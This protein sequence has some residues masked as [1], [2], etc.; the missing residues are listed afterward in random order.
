[1]DKIRGRCVCKE[2][3]VAE[4]YAV[5][6]V[7]LNDGCYTTFH[8]LICANCGGVAGT[9]EANFNMFLEK[10]PDDLVQSMC[11]YFN[12]DPNRREDKE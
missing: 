2:H 9:P 1:M 11:E 5:T 8:I 3:E 7:P 6:E 12:F 10:G 4:Q